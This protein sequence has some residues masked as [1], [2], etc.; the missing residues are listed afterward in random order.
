MDAKPFKI[1]GYQRI[2]ERLIS[3]FEEKNEKKLERVINK[4]YE[5]K[6][7]IEKSIEEKRE[8]GW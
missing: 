8:R 1:S 3:E 6:L 2:R 4:Q 7:D 5:Y